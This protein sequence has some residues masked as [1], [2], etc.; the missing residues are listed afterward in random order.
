MITITEL[1]LRKIKEIFALQNKDFRTTF[2]FITVISGGCSGFSYEMDLTDTQTERDQVYEF[3]LPDASP[4]DPPLKVVIPTA[5]SEHLRGSEIDYL[6][7]EG[8]EAFFFR[9]PNAKSTCGC[10][11]SFE[12]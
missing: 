7:S 5:H 4:E 2:L 9:N 8:G 10:G 12:A 11:H 1:A 6:I 3:K